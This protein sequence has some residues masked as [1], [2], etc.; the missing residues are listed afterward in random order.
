MVGGVNLYLVHSAQIV[1][2]N[3]AK[4][5]YYNRG[6]SESGPTSV[7]IHWLEDSKDIPFA[8]VWN[9]W[10][11]WSV[12][13]SSFFLC[14]LEIT[15]RSNS[16]AFNFK[17]ANENAFKKNLFPVYNVL[18]QNSML[19]KYLLKWPFLPSHIENCSFVVIIYS[20]HS[21]FS[22]LSWY[23]HDHHVLYSVI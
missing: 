8:W 13:S 7:A 23:K 18:L 14:I 6:L 12:L 17:A 15:K 22:C 3:L 19:S 16:I 1:A 5:L 2:P 4:Q 21:F 9:T 10:Q 11:K 20:S